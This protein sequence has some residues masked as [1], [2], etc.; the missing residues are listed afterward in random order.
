MQIY[1]A[2]TQH[3]HRQ[4][5]YMERRLGQLD[6]SHFPDQNTHRLTL[7]Q[8]QTIKDLLHDQMAKVQDGDLDKWTQK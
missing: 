3:L 2:K 7:E 1:Q 6:S 4:I 5:G 8:I